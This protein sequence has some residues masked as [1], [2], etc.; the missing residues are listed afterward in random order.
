MIPK[1]CQQF[2]QPASWQDR[3]V[4]RVALFCD[5]RPGHEKQ[6][7]GILQALA[8]MVA[9]EVVTVDV[10]ALSPVQR[11]IQLLALLSPLPWRGE[12]YPA[13]D[14][15]LGAGS[16]SHLA[17]LLAKKA[18]GTPAVVCMSPLALLRKR[19]DL[20]L[21]PVHDGLAEGGNVFCT[22]GAPNCSI[23]LRRHRDD[24][25][26]IALGGVDRRSHSW[27]S[28]EMV[29]MAGELVG[30]ERQVRWTL[31]SS[32]RTPEETARG[33]A[34][35]AECHEHVE[36]FDYRH[37]ARGWIEERYADSATVW[38]SADSV[39]MVYEALSAGCRVGLLPV[40]WE[41]GAAKFRRNE[42]LLLRRGL[43]L[44]FARW[45]AGDSWKEEDH[46]FNEAQRCA[47]RILRIWQANA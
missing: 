40:R 41:S 9:V 42:E 16:R 22:L 8:A 26:L 20:C 14:L 27:S 45:Q 12:A 5:G 25:G 43:V 19:F 6:S 11:I 31:T 30:R 2:P 3:G 39:S 10:S 7:R 33:L 29:A 23:D 35:L 36:F 44:P 1:S 46:H 37:T 21:V 15:L 28:E 32:P 38:V 24:C 34:R 47:E 4:L 17:M 18:H 13:A